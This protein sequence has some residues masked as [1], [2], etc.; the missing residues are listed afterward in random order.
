MTNPLFCT[1]RHRGVI[2]A[3]ENSR[4]ISPWM[5]LCGGASNG[6]AGT[7]SL[8]SGSP[9]TTDAVTVKNIVQAMSAAVKKREHR[10]PN[11]AL[12]RCE[13][14]KYMPKRFSVRHAKLTFKS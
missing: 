3:L 10:A 11:V 4:L 5:R 7:G 1:S 8:A 2:Y 14:V 12:M 13:W 9:A 6:G